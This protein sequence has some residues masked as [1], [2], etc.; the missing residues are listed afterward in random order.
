M[1]DPR[2]LPGLF[3]LPD[4]VRALLLQRQIQVGE[5][6]PLLFQNIRRDVVPVHGVDHGQW[7]HGTGAKDKG[8]GRGGARHCMDRKRGSIC[9]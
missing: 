9:S 7:V 3:E 8:V 1:P 6:R 2:P 5:D 4:E